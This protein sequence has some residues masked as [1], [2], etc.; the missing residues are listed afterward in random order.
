[1]CVY[2]YA[3]FIKLCVIPLNLHVCIDFVC[4]YACVY[5]C[6]LFIKLRVV[7][8][9]LHACNEYVNVRVR[10]CMCVCARVRMCVCVFYFKSPALNTITACC[11]C[12]SVCMC[13]CFKHTC[14]LCVYVSAQVFACMNASSTP[15]RC[16]CVYVR[17]RACHAIALTA[18]MPLQHAHFKTFPT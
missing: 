6:A 15:A 14:A 12:S 3:P 9:Y 13:E 17:A 2:V 8:P 5:V 11:E 4:V 16:M 7:L 1:M 10:V 18:Y